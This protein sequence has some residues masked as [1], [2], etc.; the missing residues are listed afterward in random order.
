MKIK[1]VIIFTICLYI[2]GCSDK[3]K[4]GQ[5]NL[6]GAWYFIEADSY[7]ELHF[8]ENHLLLHNEL[9]GSKINEYEIS[10]NNVIQVLS[11]GKVAEEYKI[12]ELSSENGVIVM[13][14]RAV[15]IQRLN[16]HFDIS[17]VLEGED[18]A[19]KNF[20]KQFNQ[21]QSKYLNQTAL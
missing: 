8:N 10:D 12:E 19:Y 17:K 11:K 4:T 14:N 3:E 2:L 1:S 9:T 20:A 18:K 7:Y 6:L 21:R 15:K 13:Q 5:E 16:N